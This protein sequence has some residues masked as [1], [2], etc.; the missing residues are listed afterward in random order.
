[1]GTGA[2]PL[3]PN[4]A[5]SRSA[6]SVLVG[7]PVR[8]PAALDIADDQRQLE[9]DREADRLCLE[10]EPGPAG[11]GDTERAAEGRAERGADA[12][13]FVLGLEGPHPEPLVLGQLV[14][15][16]ATPA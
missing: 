6:C 14:Q 11:R 8:G 10:G 13:D 15:N 12:G 1:M 3:R 7:S 5:C 9:R 2:S 4:I 16:V